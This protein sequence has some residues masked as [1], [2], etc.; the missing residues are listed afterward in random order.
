LKT[1]E[2]T[3]KASKKPRGCGKDSTEAA[4]ARK[5]RRLHLQ[6]SLVAVKAT[7]AA[8]KAIAAGISKLIAAIAAGG[9]VAL[10]IIL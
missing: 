10:V 7:V 8:V 4:Q 2:Q 6:S 1:A 9:W 3:A 5:M